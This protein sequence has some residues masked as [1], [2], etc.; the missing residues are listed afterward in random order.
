MWCWPMWYFQQYHV[1]YT[2]L[3]FIV[4]LFHIWYKIRSLVH[5][6]SFSL[7]K[8]PSSDTSFDMIS[9][10]EL[11]NRV[12]LLL[13]SMSFRLILVPV[14]SCMIRRPPDVIPMPDSSIIWAFNLCRHPSSQEISILFYLTE[15]CP[16]FLV[17]HNDRMTNPKL[18][19]V[20]LMS[21]PQDLRQPCSIRKLLKA[22]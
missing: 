18:G 13:H 10:T 2:S 1:D 7:M 8:S 14:I 3:T 12:F 19:Q 15:C 16:N 9:L 5:A 22:Y 17:C 11:Y 6:W 21:W 4:I 20:L